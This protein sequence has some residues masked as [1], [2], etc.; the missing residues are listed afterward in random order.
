MGIAQ[1]LQV[2][3]RLSEGGAAG[4]ARNISDELNR[5]GIRAPFAYGYG[6][7]GDRSPDEGATNAIRLTPKGIAAANHLAYGIVGRETRLASPAALRNLDE[8]LSTTDV[9]H[10]HV[11]HSYMINTE[12]LFEK[13]IRA[14]KPVVWTLH[15][16]WAMTG[17]CAQPGSC[18]RWTEGCF[19]C[20]D[21]SAYPPARIDFAASRWTQRR[22]AIERLQA[23]LPTAIVPC[24]SWLGEAASLA[25]LKNI[26]VI[27]NSVDSVFW[28]ATKERFESAP[29][30]GRTPTNRNLFMCRDLRDKAKVD[31]ALLSRVAELRNQQLTI[32]GDNPPKRL[33]TAKYSPAISSRVDLA[34]IFAEHDRLIFT[35]QVDYFPLT[36]AEAIASG[37]M[38]YAIRSRASEEFEKSEL[39]S[40]FDSAESMIRCL[41]LTSSTHLGPVALTREREFFNPTRM[42]EEYLEL[43]RSLGDSV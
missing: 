40:L 2:N 15:D 1:V 16:Q 28:E 12:L 35:S 7:H 37:V 10:L 8:V 39:V 42:T 18:S 11:V 32:V 30:S 27:K 36:I 21:L 17:R 31:W 38:V 33:A 3:V 9:V 22:T 26:S 25:G 34:K 6:P 20:P 24:A 13:L 14:G 29:T 5:R 41:E 4:V 43:Y 23:E 19:A